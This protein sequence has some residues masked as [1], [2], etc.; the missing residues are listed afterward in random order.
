[1]ANT[2]P[3]ETVLR[4]RQYNEDAQARAL[5]RL[6]MERQQL[7]AMLVRVQTEVQQWGT[8]RTRDAGSV[9]TGTTQ[10]STYARLHLLRSTEK[11]LLE[12]LA[13]VD[14]RLREQRSRFL[15]ARSNREMLTELKRQDQITRESAMQRRE[16][17]QL[18]ELLLGRWSR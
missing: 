6:G 7:E 2:F 10:H 17:R 8:D 9:G 12:Q 3:L 5:A 16:Q 18:E 13:S 14:V 15:A 1:M 4:V 11:Q